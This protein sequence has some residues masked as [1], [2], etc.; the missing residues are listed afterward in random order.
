MTEE[1]S[2]L[3][4]ELPRRLVVIGD[5][6]A[7]GG[8]LVRVLRGLRLINAEHHWSGGRTV[9]VQLG[10][11]PNRG[12]SARAAMELLLALG[13]EAREAGGD[14]LWL[15]GNHE[16][17]SALRHEAY[18]TAEEYLEFATPPELEVFFQERTRFQYQFLGLPRDDGSVPPMAGLLRAWEDE[19]APG[20]E[21]YQRAMGPSG[22]LGRAIRRLPIAVRFG[23][24]LLVHGGLSPKWADFGIEGL[25]K[26]AARA[27]AQKPTSYEALDPHSILRDPL[28]P[29]WNRV[30]C[31]SSAER[32]GSDLS[33]ALRMVGAAQMIVGHT[34]TDAAPDGVPGRPLVRHRGRLIMA[35]VGLGDPGEPPAVLVIERGRIEVWTPGGGRSRVADIR[36]RR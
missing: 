5:L 25:S 15:L 24:V 29:V 32:V 33:E 19:N 12:P 35:D 4:R 18:V 1:L 36:L 6:N 14:V 10:D 20:R 22:R 30:Y 11:V 3:E 7:F 27:W 9:V 13:P 26:L 31:L 23:P 21:E 17:L 2:P 8:I 34:R 28:G 16:V